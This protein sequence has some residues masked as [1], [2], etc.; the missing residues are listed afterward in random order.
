[1][2]GMW[3]LLWPAV[4]FLGVTIAALLLRSVLTRT[5]RRWLSPTSVEVFLRAIRLP[6]ILWCFVFGLFVALEVVEIPQRLATQLHNLLEAAIILSVTVTVASVLASLAAAA[7]ERRALGIGMTGLV[8]TAVR[9]AILLIGV[10]V[11]LGSLGV[12]ITPL[13]TA[14]GVGGLAVALALQDTLSNLFAGVH[15]L[16]DKPIRVG[17]Y[18]KIADAI[19][20]HVIDVGW[21][22]TRVLMLAHNVVI[23]PNKRV[24]E[25]IIVNYDL[26]ER[27]MAL[28]IRVTVDYASDPD[29]IEA[30]LVDEARRAAGE[31]AGL[32]PEPAPSAKLIPGFGEYSLE[33][34]LG[35]QVASFVDQYDVQH[36]LRKRILRRFRAEGIEIPYPIRTVETRTRGAEP[37]ASPR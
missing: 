28:G 14:L 20:G 23:V 7:G 35:C 19:E 36:E 30:L 25:S 1:M 21:R 2:L 34:T 9:G 27:R 10:L 15:L 37:P 32:L 22:S 16:A 26:P 12:H 4:A 5:L 18:V 6:S 33:F 29:R 13:L 31:V 8:R 3:P 11:L 17:D 24:A